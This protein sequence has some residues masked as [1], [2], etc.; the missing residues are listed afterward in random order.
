MP[1]LESA[2]IAAPFNSFAAGSLRNLKCGRQAGQR[3]TTE[4]SKPAKSSEPPNQMRK[5]YHV[6]RKLFRAL[7]PLYFS[8]YLF[9]VTRGW[10]KKTRGSI[11]APF[12][13][14]PLFGLAMFQ[15]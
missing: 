13:L 14:L 7:S 5:I 3:H 2:A 9:I 4:L 8:A 15:A 6:L 11:R 12:P 1:K 10:H